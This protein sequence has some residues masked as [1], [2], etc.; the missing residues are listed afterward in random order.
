V[1]APA[2]NPTERFSSRARDY[3]RY[4]PSYPAA[5]FD[6]LRECCGLRS[7]TRVADVGSGTGILTAQLLERE[8]TVFAVEP[9]DAMRAHAEAMLAGRC[10][11]HSVKGTA[12]ATTLGH[13]QVSLWVAGQAF[14]WFDP[15]AARHE[16]LRIGTA[17]CH[18][19]LL[20]N[21]RPVGST[22]F[23]AEYE[24]LLHRYAP[25]YAAIAARRADEASMRVFFGG[26]MQVATFPNSQPLDFTG[27]SGRLRS[28]SY[29]PEP[30]HALHEPLMSA[31]RAVFD[32][33][34]RGG[35]VT[36]PYLTFVN[37]G[38]LNR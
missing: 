34:A 5:A 38:V 29:A 22:G 36:F 1:T 9:N 6:L 14:H 23:F 13:G 12:E 33:H 28:S 7:G 8:A 10:G 35:L 19:A 26:T 32:R 16:A 21:E 4:R 2:L 18:A 37:Y 27:L 20:G 3:A 15:L 30:G 17:P 11:F 25:E 31:L 24:A